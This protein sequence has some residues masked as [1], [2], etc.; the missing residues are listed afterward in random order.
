VLI[1]P[2]KMKYLQDKIT[3][4]S[5]ASLLGEVMRRAHEGRS[6]GEMFNE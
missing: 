1:P 5:V 2:K 6:V 4:I 3:V